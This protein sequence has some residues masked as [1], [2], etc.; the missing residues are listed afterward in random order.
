MIGQHLLRAGVQVAGA[1]VVAEPLPG[2]E[3]VVELGLGQ[4]L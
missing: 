2:V 1:G 4:R 3:H